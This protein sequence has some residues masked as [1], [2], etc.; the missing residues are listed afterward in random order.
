MLIKVCGMRE[1]G[2]MAAIAALCPDM[3]GFIFYPLSPRYAGNLLPEAVCMLPP[4]IQR[5]GVFVNAGETVI[6]E[7][8]ERYNI[9]VVQLHGVESPEFCRKFRDKG[10]QVV[11]ALGIGEVAD[12]ETCVAYEGC[13]DM[14]LFD[15]KS[16][17]YG[18][19]G[20]AF[21]WKL[22]ETYRG[23]LPFLLSG[24]I[25]PADALSI[26]AFRHP[27]FAGIDL[28]SRFETEPGIKDYELLSAF[29]REL[30]S[31]DF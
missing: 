11:K 23:E 26:K 14:L 29:I 15:T 12:L 6:N 21:D 2:N 5:T 9:G 27:R 28:N 20:Q 3:L 16:R 7:I 13:C 1:P 8:V 10:F 30:R 25:S 24:G 18:G 19:T 31:F 22:L 4:D 17:K